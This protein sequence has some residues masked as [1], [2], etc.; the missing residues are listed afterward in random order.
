DLV[1]RV[2]RQA[3]AVGYLVGA[4]FRGYD[5]PHVVHR[6]PRHPARLDRCIEPGIVLQRPFQVVLDHVKRHTA[7]YRGAKADGRAFFSP[8]RRTERLHRNMLTTRSD[9]SRRTS[10]ASAT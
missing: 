8:A 2:D 6:V 10:G 1:V 9:A 3:D 5:E 7:A 4:H